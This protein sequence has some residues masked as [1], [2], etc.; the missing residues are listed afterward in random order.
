MKLS[1]GIILGCYAYMAGLAA[2]VLHPLDPAALPW[3]RAGTALT[4][5]AAALAFGAAGRG[6][7][8]SG[9][10]RRWAA[11]LLCGGAVLLGMTRHTGANTMP[12]MRIGEF[13]VQ[14]PDRALHLS[15][16]LPDTSRVRIRKTGPLERDLQFRLMGELDARIPERNAE[17]IPVMD[18]KGRWKFRIARTAVVSDSI[19]IRAEDPPGSEVISRQPFT[20]L[21][22]VEWIDGPDRGAVALYRV[23]N[24]IGSFVRAAR[25]QSPVTVLGR[26]TGDPRVYDFQTILIVTPEFIQYPA[27]GPFYRVEGGDIQVTVQPHMA[28]Y[29]SFARTSA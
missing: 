21:T 23:S 18:A 4:L 17:G 15:A 9:A 16:P 5:G 2:M 6:R 29:S 22:G 28:G 3:L 27:N 10:A 12:D 8:M 1:T 26:I 7:A 11:F 20:R 19:V 13:R 24:H 14:G 25:A